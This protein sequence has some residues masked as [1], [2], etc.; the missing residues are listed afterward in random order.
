MSLTSTPAT[1]ASRLARLLPVPAG[2]GLAR[3][4]VERNLMSF[5]H[6]WLALLTGFAEPVFYLFSLGIGLAP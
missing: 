5:R 6:G 1:T 4:L 3:I 2:A